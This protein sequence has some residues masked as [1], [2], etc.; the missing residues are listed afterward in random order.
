M[1]VPP[2]SEEDLPK[3]MTDVTI[4][5]GSGKLVDAL[6][7]QPDRGVS[8]TNRIVVAVI[9]R[10]G[11][12]WFFKL[13][14]PGAL[15]LKEEPTFVEFLKSVDFTKTDQF[16]QAAMAGQFAG[17]APAPGPDSMARPKWEV[18]EGWKEI[19][20]GQMVLNRFSLTEAGGKK[21]EVTVS[22]AGGG[23]LLNVNRWRGQ[24]GLPEIAE[25]QLKTVALPFD[26]PGEKAILVDMSGTDKG[27]RQARLIAVIIPRTEGTWFYKTLMGDQDLADHQKEVFLKF[28]QTVR[29]PNA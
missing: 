15:V 25:S 20:A 19:A 8:H 1:N 23:L 21:A 14:G 24:L 4:G 22:T 16:V 17:G 18:P 2:A 26:V 10:K 13:Q 5:D 12:T 9:A 3:L 27:G 29:Y 7:A 11:F 6:A 28:V